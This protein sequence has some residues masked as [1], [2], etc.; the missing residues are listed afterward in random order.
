[1]VDIVK[2]WPSDLQALIQSFNEAVE[3][4][5]ETAT[6]KII[7]KLV[8]IIIDGPGTETEVNALWAISSISQEFPEKFRG[9]IEV[10]A[11]IVGDSYKDSFVKIHGLDTLRNVGSKYPQDLEGHLEGIVKNLFEDFDL[12]RKSAARAFE[13]VVIAHPELIKGEKLLLT[14][15]KMNKN[16]PDPRVREL[17]EA[18]LKQ[19]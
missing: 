4:K 12:L 2:K 1:M 6:K 16:D 5:D 10:I 9:A 14:E 11:G 7:Q 13:D 18:C 17:V 8:G 3:A 19:L 15:L